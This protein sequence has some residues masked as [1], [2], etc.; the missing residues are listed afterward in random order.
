ML[1]ECMAS[2]VKKGACDTY[3]TYL[4]EKN[5]PLTGD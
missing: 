2:T 4:V 3:R 5:V 1:L